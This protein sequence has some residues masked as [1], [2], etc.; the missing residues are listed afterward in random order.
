MSGETDAADKAQLGFLGLF[1]DLTDDDPLRG[2]LMVTDGNGHPLELRV[3]TPVRATRLQRAAYGESLMPYALGELVGAPLIDRVRLEPE[4]MLVNRLDA[5]DMLADEDLVYIAEADGYV[6][7]DQ[8]ES[9]LLAPSAERVPTVIACPTGD[10][11]R[12]LAD[13]SALLERARERFDP[14]GVFDRLE[15]TLEVLAESDDRYR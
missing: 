4:V 2:A 9:K 8:H 6:A 12:S 14:L 7:L 1:G 3:A 11:A 5:L 13:V 10:N 15:T